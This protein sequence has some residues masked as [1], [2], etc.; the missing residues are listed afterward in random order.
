VEGPGFAYAPL[1]SETNF[2]EEVQVEIKETP[3]SGMFKELSED[4]KKESTDT[5]KSGPWNS[6]LS[7][8][9]V[10][11]FLQFLSQDRIGLN[12]GG[13]H[14]RGQS[15]FTLEFTGLIYLVLYV[16]LFSV[17]LKILEPVISN[18][19]MKVGTDYKEMDTIPELTLEKFN[20]YTN[21]KITIESI[22]MWEDLTCSDMEGIIKSDNNVRVNLECVEDTG[23]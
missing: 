1:D 7:I 8:P 19:V 20:Y 18:E 11:P 2:Q 14:H 9:L 6:F 3:M 16:F 5:Q 22:K 12:F 23:K 13:M 17:D 10:R 21:M 4:T 15:S